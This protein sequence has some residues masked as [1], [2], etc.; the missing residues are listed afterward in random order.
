MIKE[1][2]KENI[3]IIYL[4]RPGQLNALDD[5]AI[6]SIRDILQKYE[7]D[8]KVKAVLFD[9]LIEKGFSAGGDLKSMYYDYLVNENCKE[10][11]GL[12]KNEFDLDKYVASYSK[13]I[14]S[15]WFGITMGG[16]IGLTI[17]SDYIIVEEN[18]NWAMPETS[19]GFSPDVG[20]GKFI[21]SLPQALGQYVGLCGASLEASDLIKYGFANIYIKSSDYEDVINNLFTLSNDYDGKDLIKQFSKSIDSY[22]QQLEESKINKNMEKIDKYFSHPSIEEIF[23]DLKKNEINDD[24]EK[25]T[26]AILKERDP[27]SLAVQ[28]EKYFADKD[29]TYEEVIDRD[30]RIIQNSMQEKIVNEGIRAKIIEKDN[31]PNWPHKSIEEVSMDDVKKLLA[32]EKS[33]KEKSQ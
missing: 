28:F 2:I 33:Y 14:I 11:D 32:I 22:R 15:H 9:S 10:I 1:K 17:N 5:N 27:F 12:L 18:I 31:N 16:G 30:L 6:N 20:V 13:P 4:D 7:Q 29:F 21:A 8:D 26:L 24:F 3:G 23:A 19:L 25:N